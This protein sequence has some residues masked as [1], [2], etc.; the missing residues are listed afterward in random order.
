MSGFWRAALSDRHCARQQLGDKAHAAASSRVQIERF[1]RTE[2]DLQLR[3]YPGRNGLACYSHMAIDDV[4]L[5]RPY[6]AHRCSGLGQLAES[7]HPAAG[8]QAHWT[9]EPGY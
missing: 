1:I 9:P 3:V 6:T 5:V 7:W 4:S 8:K 2:V